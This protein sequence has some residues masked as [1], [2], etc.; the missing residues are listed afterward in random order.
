MSRPLVLLSETLRI[1]TPYVACA[2]GA[3]VTERAGIVNV[4]F[5][6]G[7]LVSGLT[8]AAVCI[9]TGSGTLGLL[10]GVAAGALLAF[11]HGVAVV[12][13]HAHAIVSG[14]ALNLIAFGLSRVVLRLLYQSASNSPPVPGFGRYE[15]T[16]ALAPLVRVALDPVV[17][18]VVVA[19]IVLSP[20]LFR[21]RFGLRLRAVGENPEAAAAAGIDAPRVQIAASTLAGALGGLGGVHLVFDQHHFDAGMSGGRGFI[22]LA[23]VIVGRHDPRRAALACLGFAAL[24]TL[25][26]S[27]QDVAKI[28]SEA[29]QMIPYLVT[30][31]VLAYA[32][33][34]ATAR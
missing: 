31:A 13:A 9:G 6:G 32:G 29:V 2:L 21:T 10:A 3:V 24:E 1:A 12:R 27:A 11:V 5:E 34:A 14:I 8:A 17:L 15:G 25:Q 33:R 16:S 7:L 19:A 30:I 22:A 20:F 26:I 28:P 18:L 23:A 4:A